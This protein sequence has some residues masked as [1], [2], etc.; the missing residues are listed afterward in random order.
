LEGDFPF[1]ISEARSLVNLINLPGVRTLA[2]CTV[3]SRQT[4]LVIVLDLTQTKK[5]VPR[6]PTTAV[7]VLISKSFFLNFNRSLANTLKFMIRKP[8]KPFLKKGKIHF[9]LRKSSLFRPCRNPCS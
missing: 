1:R 2:T 9:S 7:G 4:T 8:M 5:R 6:T 3:L